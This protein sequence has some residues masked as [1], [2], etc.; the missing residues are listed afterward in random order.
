MLVDAFTKNTYIKT[1]DVNKSISNEELIKYHH[2][3]QNVPSSVLRNFVSSL[4]DTELHKLISNHISQFLPSYIQIVPLKSS[5]NY[6]KKQIQTMP[7]NIHNVQKTTPL[8]YNNIN[9]SI[10]LKT[11]ELILNESNYITHLD[12]QS[13]NLLLSLPKNLLCYIMSFINLKEKAMNCM[14]TCYLLHRIG[15]NKTTKYELNLTSQTIENIYNKR[16]KQNQIYDFKSIKFPLLTEKNLIY[17]NTINF[18]KLLAKTK[19]IKLHY[20]SATVTNTNLI[21]FKNNIQKNNKIHHKLITLDFGYRTMELGKTLLSKCKNLQ[22]CIIDFSDD[23]TLNNT[24]QIDT[25]AILYKNDHLGKTLKHLNLDWSYHNTWQTESHIIYNLK[26]FKNLK[27]LKLKLCIPDNIIIKTE[28]PKF[29]IQCLA[30]NW[31]YTKPNESND[32]QQE[33]YI[34]DITEQNY[35]TSFKLKRWYKYI[36]MITQNIIKNAPSLTEFKFKIP[37]W[38][39][40]INTMFFSWIQTNITITHLILSIHAKH[41]QYLESSFCQ[42]ES[43]TIYIDEC[44]DLNETLNEIQRIMSLI[45][46]N[47]ESKVQT[48]SMYLH[49]LPTV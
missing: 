43:V 24:K 5:T 1:M 9:M 2:N 26:K 45:H 39:K 47:S 18:N 12:M 21:K 30:I 28:Y 14:L 40:K 7:I 13:E 41:I 46:M 11:K 34:T 44:N 4:S 20:Q 38:T 17:L 36:S 6:K 16:I 10:L 35:I 3:I 19:H 22:R 32:L 23:D 37:I 33:N 27:S 25:F 48:L 8:T 49:Y 42:F 31:Y 29:N 15:I